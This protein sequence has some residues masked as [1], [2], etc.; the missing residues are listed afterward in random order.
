MAIR[1]VK[2]EL[3]AATPSESLD[4]LNE[5]LRTLV[6]FEADAMLP[7]SKHTTQSPSDIV[8]DYLRGIL[9]CIHDTITMSSA[10]LPSIRM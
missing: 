2:L 10:N 6:E 8:A 4:C 5:L 9:T 1:H 3:R 7:V